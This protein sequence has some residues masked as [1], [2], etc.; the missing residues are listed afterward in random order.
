[1]NCGESV[2]G[3]LVLAGLSDPCGDIGTQCR[4]DLLPIP[5][6]GGTLK[7]SIVRMLKAEQW[8]IFT[9]ELD[10]A[11]AIGVRFWIC[12]P[13]KIRSL[14]LLMSN[15]W[16]NR[17]GKKA[18]SLIDGLSRETP[19]VEFV[20]PSTDPDDAVAFSTLEILL[21]QTVSTSKSV[22]ANALDGP[23]TRPVELAASTDCWVGDKLFFNAGNEDSEGLELAELL[24]LGLIAKLSGQERRAAAAVAEFMQKRAENQARAAHDHSI[25]GV[26]MQ[27]RALLEMAG[28]QSIS[29]DRVLRYLDDTLEQKYDA[30]NHLGI[31][32]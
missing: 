13:P 31:E 12:P 3:V 18:A 14:E 4:Y 21:S 15:G 22:F 32:I 28:S 29:A 8:T 11:P 30:T 17:Q 23:V 9:E 16:S 24:R 20:W 19:A 10:P 25:V 27:D 5:W 26:V 6:E 2:K 1:M 7:S